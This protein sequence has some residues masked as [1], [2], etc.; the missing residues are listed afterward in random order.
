MLGE[1]QS[2]EVVLSIDPAPDRNIT[3]TLTIDDPVQIAAEP[4][5][6][7]FTKGTA[8]TRAVTIAVLEDDV[9]E[10]SDVFTISIE[11]EEGIAA[12]VRA[13]L[14]VIV[15]ADN[16]NLV[17]LP[18][19]AVLQRE[20]TLA[21]GDTEE[22][23]L[24]RAPDDLTGPTTIVLIL[25]AEDDLVA[26]SSTQVV[27]NAP[28]ENKGVT[29][30]ANDDTDVVRNK[31]VV[32][33]LSAVDNSVHL[34]SNQIEVIIE[35]DDF[36]QIG[37]DQKKI[38]IKEGSSAEVSL[39]ISPSPVPN[40]LITA[41][42]TI[43]DLAAEQ[44]TAAPIKVVFSETTLRSA[45]TIAVTED[46]DPEPKQKFT[47]GI[48]PESRL[49]KAG[50]ELSVVVPADNDNLALLRRIAVLQRT[51]TLTEGGSRAFTLFRAPEDLTGPTTITFMP[52]RDGVLAFNPEQVILTAQDGD[53]KVTI[54]ADDN[55]DLAQNTTVII[56]LVAESDHDTVQLFPG[57]TILT[58]I[59]DND[60]Y[61]IGFDKERIQI[62]G[63][64][65]SAVS[66]RISPPPKPAEVIIAALTFDSDQITASPD[67]ILFS[68]STL[69]S[70]ITVTVLDNTTREVP[71]E[72]F[73]LTL[74]DRQERLFDDLIDQSAKQIRD[75][76]LIEK[77]TDQMLA[78]LSPAISTPI[79]TPTSTPTSGMV[80]GQSGFYLALPEPCTDIEQ[81]SYDDLRT[82]AE[83]FLGK[84]SKASL[85]A[86][87]SRLGVRREC[88]ANSKDFFLEEILRKAGAGGKAAQAWLLFQAI[89]EG[90]ILSAHD[91]IGKGHFNQLDQQAFDL[92]LQKGARCRNKL[93]SEL[94]DLTD[95]AQKR[96][97]E[98]VFDMIASAERCK[99]DK[100]RNECL[101][102]PCSTAS[103]RCVK[104]R[105]ECDC[106]HVECT[107]KAIEAYKGLNDENGNQL[108]AQ[109]LINSVIGKNV[110]QL[111]EDR[112]DEHFVCPKMV[113]V[114]PGSFRMGSPSGEAKRVDNEGPVHTV[115]IT[116]TFAVSIH[117]VTFA[118]WDHCA[119][120]GGCS[121]GIYSPHDESWGRRD[122]PV[123]NVSW[124]DAKA[125]VDWL[126]ERTGKPYR[127]LTEA[128]WEYAARAGTATPFHFGNTISA[129]QA[130]Y[131]GRYLYPSIDDY[132]A[133]GTYRNQT[134][135]VG[136]F[137][138]NKFGLHDV[139]GNV[140][141]WVEDC[142]HEDYEGAPADGSAW[143]A[144]GDCSLR[145]IRGGSWFDF[146]WYLR[147]ALRGR[148]SADVPS[149]YYGFRVA[150][151]LTP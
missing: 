124:H 92:C 107:S 35:E 144:G 80:G 95:A 135:P 38:R 102:L 128:E 134:I 25:P 96:M 17:S 41:A 63:G 89:T 53:V 150:L 145:V 20:L 27:L 61:R 94:S 113:A 10:G 59:E 22:F 65:S 33:T 77:I 11:P 23:I 51:L 105:A 141:E 4:A 136:S 29:I 84:L 15:P 126:S 49:A 44:L 40:E 56:S 13:G 62:E 125:Y 123:I 122:R 112:C 43:G 72:L 32:I 87:S 133:A 34:S 9:P 50:A 16:D 3:V 46:N 151:T 31:S 70:T 130:N 47:I 7:V 108:I 101:F 67:R 81:L 149:R 12:Q 39:S 19:I 115:T 132:D 55:T 58:I 5:A 114:P 1:G 79:S 131:D 120:Q 100:A 24:F 139:H 116:Y 142:W 103:S 90:A 2:T 68:Q 69:R 64:S 45:V 57:N 14:S 88:A 74:S 146:P 30:K 109:S 106:N 83:S 71:A 138:A 147:S 21:E 82:F 99:C 137:P 98:G 54:R 75:D 37:F 76:G 104:G 66:L 18:Q 36:Y 93:R 143:T 60:F 6:I 111:T 127:L 140:W 97:F 91:G 148:V 85:C 42:L 52:G 73:I 118:E 119:A 8:S 26:L 117:E 86:I 78:I 110:D 48:Q 28:G 129:G 121:S